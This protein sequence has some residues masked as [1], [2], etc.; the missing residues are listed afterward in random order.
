MRYVILK[1]ES[2]LRALQM[3]WWEQQ[4]VG[5]SLARKIITVQALWSFVSYLK[6]V[7]TL[8]GKSSGYWCLLDF[9]DCSNEKYFLVKCDVSLFVGSLESEC[10]PNAWTGLKEKVFWNF[11]QISYC[12]YVWIKCIFVILWDI[13]VV[14]TACYHNECRNWHITCLQVLHLVSALQICLE[15]LDAD[16]IH[17]PC[18]Q[19]CLNILKY[20]G[21][22]LLRFL[23]GL[24]NDCWS[25]LWALWAGLWATE[26]VANNIYFT[27]AKWRSRYMF[28]VSIWSQILW[29]LFFLIFCC[30]MFESFNFRS[31]C[32]KHSKHD[33]WK[34]WEVNQQPEI[35]KHHVSH[36]P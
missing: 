12:K 5:S 32:S 8:G 29:R 25:G 18:R 6:E 17:T 31:L 15:I 4:A 1:L 34:V 2:D 26:P 35:W 3:N 7:N 28:N 23:D 30:K 20:L 27:W 19:F 24:C 10:I 22:N 16:S 11:F 14:P 13:V 9:W 36:S 21:R 33:G